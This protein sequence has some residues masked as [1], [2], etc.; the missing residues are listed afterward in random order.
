MS[1]GWA[2]Y[3]RCLCGFFSSLLFISIANLLLLIAFLHFALA[4][5]D[6]CVCVCKSA[7]AKRNNRKM[8]LRREWE[9]KQQIHRHKVKQ[10][11]SSIE[12]ASNRDRASILVLRYARCAMAAAAA[13]VAAVVY[14]V[15]YCIMNLRIYCAKACSLELV[16]CT[17]KI[18]SPPDNR[19]HRRKCT[20]CWFY[21]TVLRLF[22]RSFVS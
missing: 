2:H 21:C 19:Q 14:C 1:N 10:S 12:D 7:K 3:W 20:E 13:A 15:L 22:G 17:L 18:L 6:V 8:Y 11:R 4:S 16:R 5:I 9:K